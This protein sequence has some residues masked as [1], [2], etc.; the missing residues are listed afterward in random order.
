M[1][2]LFDTVVYGFVVDVLTGVEESDCFFKSPLGGCE[3]S[4][5]LG[6]VRKIER[7]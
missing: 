1:F 7:E 4:A 2:V 5:G 3:K 6:E